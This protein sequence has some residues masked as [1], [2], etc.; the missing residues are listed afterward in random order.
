M[1]KLFE[2]IKS[3][4]KNDDPES[5]IKWSLYKRV[6]QEVGRP[7][8]KW[9]AAGIIC[10]IFSAGAEAFSITLVRQ[11][12]DQ[13]FIEK[14]MTSLYWI[15]IQ[16]VAAFGFK[17]IFAYSKTLLIAKAGLLAATGLR[18]RIYRHMVRMHIGLFNKSEVGKLMNYY[19][20][21][22]AAVLNLVTDSIISM[23][24]NSATLIFMIILM[25][26]YAP[27]MFAVLLFLV[28]AIIVPLMII[29]RKKRKLTRRQFEIAGSSTTHINQTIQGI[30]TIQSF[31]NEE[32]EAVRFDSI[33]SKNIKNSYKT[34]QLNG[35][36]SPLLEIMISIGLGLALI[37]G[38]YFITSGQISMGDFTA[39]ILALTA[40]YQPAKKITGVGGGIQNGLIGAEQLFEFLD[41]ESEIQ[42]SANAK[43]LKPGP[44]N[45]RLKNVS[46]A[47]NSADGD[48]LHDISL[49][50]APGTVCALVGP[51]GGGKSTIFNLLERFYDPQKGSVLINGKDMRKYTL[52][53]VRRNI[54]IVSQDVF[55]FNG[56]IADN[57]KYGAP[58]ATGKEIKDATIAANAHDFIKELPN[59]YKT[60]VGERGSLLSG[61]QKQR[62]AI[63]RAILKNAPILLLD[64]A[65][66]ALDTQSEKLI[67]AAL[68]KLMAGRT[69]FVIAHRLSTILDADQI[70]VMSGGRITERGTDA[71]LTKAAGDY[72]KL[73]DIQFKNNK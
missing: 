60:N 43:D 58:D 52:A 32:P 56:S 12:I 17:S 2:K 27:Q 57:I 64:E 65:T 7:Q 4:V 39:F 1:K 10:T 35:I 41:T 33:E 19:S 68:K 67:Q 22:A 23:V 47:Y 50:I 11:V 3:F 14:N 34:I 30:K 44:M 62:I 26:W 55:L 15:G 70:C 59:G 29:M 6:W 37:V 63:A 73:K 28:P 9:L 21:Q 18:R 46:F 45:V 40:A 66:S 53:S 25:L 42:D 16:I 51:S 36:Q 72:K 61:G 49:D 13:G 20:V 8:W 24:Q 48:I 5:Q 54:A 69:T 31:S 71:E 38:G